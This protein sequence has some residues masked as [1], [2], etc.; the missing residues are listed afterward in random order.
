M[1]KRS[2][3][4]FHIR[5]ARPG[6][7]LRHP[8]HDQVLHFN[9]HTAGRGGRIWLS[10]ASLIWLNQNLPQARMSLSHPTAE[11]L[12]NRLDGQQRHRIYMVT[13]DCAAAQPENVTGGR[14]V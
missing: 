1:E 3:G 14:R 4:F 13:E 8:L 6:S 5:S 9:L 10:P 7:T 2:H 12:V 11:K